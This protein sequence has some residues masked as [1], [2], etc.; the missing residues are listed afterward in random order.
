MKRG[1]S[2]L[3][4]LVAVDKP[5][6]CSSHDVVNRA[7]R[8]FGERRVGHTGTLDPLASGALPLCIG[9]ATRLDR[10]LTGHDKA[11][12]VVARFGAETDTDDAQG[13]VTATAPCPD[14]LL[15]GAFAEAYVGGLVGKHLQMPPQYSAIKV[16]GKKAYEVARSGGEAKLEPRAITIHEARLLDR[17]LN[18]ELGCVEWT[19][20]LAVS[21][22][23][24]V[25]SI[26]RDMGREL[27]SLAH[28][29][30]LRRTRAGSIGL[31][32]CHSLESLENLGTQA[33][34]D[35]VAHLGFRFLYGDDLE[36]QVA[37]GSKLDAR[38]A[39]LFRIAPSTD[40]G[41][42]CCTTQAVPDAAP[43]SPDEP[44]AVLLGNH[45]KSIYRH[46]GASG[47]LRPETVFA[48]P[49]ARR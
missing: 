41:C 3:S 2:G 38:D 24:Y 26:V 33:A 13:T 31:D 29:A 28:V 23:T 1:T 16:D 37:N 6:G 47:I 36:K 25:R 20:A 4:L 44:V 42:A 18:D 48:T 21:A 43:L 32:R 46:D 39:E 19:V 45:L 12:E 7:R 30:A 14:D 10:Y 17:R 9:P 49:I 35:P 27:G 5:T 34:L 40:H 15:D 11:Y 8:I 22:G